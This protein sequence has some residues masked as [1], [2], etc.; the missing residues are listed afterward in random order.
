M[1]SIIGGVTLVV[2]VV[3]YIDSGDDDGEKEQVIFF[4]SCL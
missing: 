2:H 3:I 4:G 1:K